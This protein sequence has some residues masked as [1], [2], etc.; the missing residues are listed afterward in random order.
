MNKTIKNLALV[1]SIPIVAIAA[2][3]M[4]RTFQSTDREAPKDETSTET[5]Y[6]EYAGRQEKAYMEHMK[7]AEENI[8]RAEEIN[9]SIASNQERYGELLQRWEQQADK[10][11]NILATLEEKSGEQPRQQ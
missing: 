10:M 7:R 6:K 4:F 1:L 5:V 11:D 8:R 9:E 3:N 2:A